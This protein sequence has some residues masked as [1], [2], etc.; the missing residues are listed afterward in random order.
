MA[1]GIRG[2]ITITML[3]GTMIPLAGFWSLDYI[4]SKKNVVSDVEM[5]LVA[6]AEKKAQHVDDWLEMNKKAMVLTAKQPSL[7][8]MNPEAAKTVLVSTNELY[9]FAGVFLA[10]LDGQQIVRNNDAALSNIADREYFKKSLKGEVGTQTGISRADK[11]P[12][13]WISAPVFDKDGKTVL[14]VLGHQNYLTS[15][16][17]FIVGEKVGRTGFS[18]L[19]DPD[20]KL[21]A[22]PNKTKT[23]AAAEG[24]GEDFKKHPAFV[25]RPTGKGTAVV[26]FSSEDKDWIS[27]VTT[28]D[29]GWTVVTQMDTEEAFEPLA[30]MTQRSAIMLASI[31]M[32]VSFL[33]F[34]VGRG[35]SSP[36]L[37]LTAIA[38]NISRGK[39][40]DAGLDAIHSKDEIGQLA[41]AVKRLSSSVKVAME[42]LSKA[43]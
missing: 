9:G 42:M 39:F 26:N 35:L 5:K 20:G 7:V 1:L 16:S 23:S 3:L 8:E 18:F 43:E 22:H 29:V 41:A 17:K 36:V 11:Q 32:I 38:D 21:I 24:T 2:K 6:V 27:V 4:N 25:N 12:V 14:G 31:F 37:K 28:T 33:A 40:D 13:M 15:I 10:G 30:A 19:L 34:F